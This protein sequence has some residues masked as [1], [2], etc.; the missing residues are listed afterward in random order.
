MSI[1]LIY[2]LTFGLAFSIYLT[3]RADI[4]GVILL[5]FVINKL[6]QFELY[7]TKNKKL[8]ILRNNFP[9]YLFVGDILLATYL[10]S[11]SLLTKEY[12]IFVIIVNA[13]IYY[14]LYK[15]IKFKN[16]LK[17][18]ITKAENLRSFKREVN[19]AVLMSYFPLYYGLLM[20]PDIN[21][22]NGILQYS[23]IA[24][25]IFV[26]ADNLYNRNK[27][28]VIKEGGKEIGPYYYIRLRNIEDLQALEEKKQILEEIKE[29][30]ILIIEEEFI[31]LSRDFSEWKV[32]R[33]K[34]KESKTI[35]DAMSKGYL[36]RICL[37]KEKDNSS[38][39][40][41]L[42]KENLSKGIDNSL[43]EYALILVSGENTKKRLTQSGIA[44]G[45]II[46]IGKPL[47]E[48][49]KEAEDI[50]ILI[51]P[52][53]EDSGVFK[54]LPN[55]LNKE[56]NWI[57]ANNQR[58]CLDISLIDLEIK[59][60]LKNKMELKRAIDEI[61]KKSEEEQMEKEVGLRDLVNKDFYSNFNG[62]L[63]D[64]S[65]NLE[66]IEKKSSRAK[67]IITDCDAPILDIVSTG[68]K[69]V[70]I[71][72]CAGLINM[73]EISGLSELKGVLKPGEY[74]E[75]DEGKNKKYIKKFDKELLKKELEDFLYKKNIT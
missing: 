11:N 61:N 54:D 75:V 66:S 25:L 4:Y 17:D 67:M 30:I 21:N 5:I 1:G 6:I 28:E 34:L 20:Y 37:K 39:I 9:T 52:T 32:V 35:K 71:K 58:I 13:Y 14:S 72:E 26:F 31:P 7:G 18:T 50:D 63:V 41:I 70:L 47:E 16:K 3:Q 43:K 49:R 8:R 62:R 36:H 57:L 64:V 51:Y 2:L 60:L 48:K 74:E 44:E 56:K 68:T 40:L 73:N 59:K 42:S 33:G 65:K 45:K 19:T 53:S 10:W 46:V 24:F 12:I 38:K 22:I 29:W 27:K 69:T 15:N 55:L 23:W